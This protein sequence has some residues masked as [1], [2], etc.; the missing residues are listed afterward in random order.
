LWPLV[1]ASAVLV[2]VW[3]GT[4][5]RLLESANDTAQFR[6]A[7]WHISTR[8]H[9]TASNAQQTSSYRLAHEHT[10]GVAL[11]SRERP[12]WKLSGKDRTDR[13]SDKDTTHGSDSD[14]DTSQ[15]LSTDSD[16]AGSSDT[17]D[18][19]TGNSDEAEAEA[20][21]E[22]ELTPQTL[23]RR[24][25]HLRTLTGR[26]AQT[27]QMLTLITQTVEVEAEAEAEAD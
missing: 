20:E 4:G 19:D 9:L 18:A 14:S 5:A 25:A 21:A 26:A 12:E 11:D 7:S 17:T 6:S 23:I 10:A 1:L 24:R 16:R 13:S 8:A 15:S 22:A 2:G 27:P 3:L